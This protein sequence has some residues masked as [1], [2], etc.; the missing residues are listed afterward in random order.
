[1]LLIFALPEKIFTKEANAESVY[2]PTVLQNISDFVISK[3]NQISW[4]Q[5][6][7]A[8]WYIN[9]AANKRKGKTRL[10]ASWRQLGFP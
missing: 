9:F 8:L 3:L 5:K 2:D 4:L 6:T 10:H 1:M 7:V